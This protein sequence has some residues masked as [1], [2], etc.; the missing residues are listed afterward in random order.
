MMISIDD[1]SIFANNISTL[2]EISK[3][4]HDG[5]DFFMT[6][7][8]LQA[9]DFD[10]VKDEY[11][12]NLRLLENPKSNDALFIQPDG[13][14]VFIEFK[15]GFMDKPKQ[16]SLRK[17]VYDSLLIYTDII[18]KGISHTRKHM[19]YILVYNDAKNTE[20]KEDPKTNMQK[21]ES[22]DLIAKRIT[23]LAGTNFVKYGLEIFKSYC[24]K[25]VYTFTEQEFKDYLDEL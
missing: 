7:S 20:L 23:R 16:Y 2:K 10:A 1:Y 5:K 19:D 17:K 9:V 22:R 3:D 4:N 13:K 12:S 21:S 18:E 6:E 24:F 14:Q 25:E 15:N 8:L 11:I